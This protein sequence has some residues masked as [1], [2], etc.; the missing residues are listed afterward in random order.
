MFLVNISGP[1][2]TPNR[3]FKSLYAVPWEENVRKRSEKR[4]NLTEKER[5]RKRERRRESTNIK[6]CARKRVCEE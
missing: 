5:T 6:M 3:R 2:K 4:K 1:S